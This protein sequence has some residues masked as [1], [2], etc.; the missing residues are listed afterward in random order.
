M[1]VGACTRTKGGHRSEETTPK[2]AAAEPR[3]D[4]GR[5][6]D[7][8]GPVAWGPQG[9]RGVRSLGD[10]K[11]RREYPNSGAADEPLG[12]SSRVIFRL[13]WRRC[14]V[15]G[16]TYLDLA[17][18]EYLAM[19]EEMNGL[20]KLELTLVLTALL[21][22]GGA[23]AASATNL[24]GLTADQTAVVLQMAG[25]FGLIVFL[26]AIGLGNM[27]IVLE[28]YVTLAGNEIERLGGSPTGGNLGTVQ[29]RIRS[30]TRSSAR[31]DRLAWL[32]SY[33]IPQVIAFIVLVIILGLAAAGF[34]G[35]SHSSPNLATWRWV[36]GLIDALLGTICF[37]ALV[38][39]LLYL[40]RWGTV[41]R[42]R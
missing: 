33:G 6:T 3:I 35:G 29:R 31:E 14:G 9:R 28:E 40:D 21:V 13:G 22:A 36:L 16:P 30:W 11:N 34:L 4:P 15:A 27:F 5:P 18:Q 12:S 19:R 7:G 10:R 26:A 25:T 23:I 20:F 42:L 37:A 8:G 39:S 2:L 32:I 1:P 17:M 24:V 38:I 41:L